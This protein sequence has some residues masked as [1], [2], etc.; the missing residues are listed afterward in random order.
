[1]RQHPIRRWPLLTPNRTRCHSKLLAYQL[2]LKLLASV[3][4]VAVDV[5]ADDEDD[6]GGDYYN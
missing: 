5:A 4:A 3:D 1:M 2:M 6:D